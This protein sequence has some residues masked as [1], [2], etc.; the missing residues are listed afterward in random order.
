MKL[1]VLGS[2]SQ[3]NCYHLTCSKGKTLIIELGEKL[4]NTKKALGFGLLGI[5]GALISHIHR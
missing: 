5:E 4:I 1:T 3:G 2:S